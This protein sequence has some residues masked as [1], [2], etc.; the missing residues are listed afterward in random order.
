VIASPTDIVVLEFWCEVPDRPVSD[1]ACLTHVREGLTTD[2]QDTAP[3]FARQRTLP[4]GQRSGR[5]TAATIAKRFSALALNGRAEMSEFT[6][7][8]GG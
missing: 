7:S 8:L 6:E 2:P 5:P 4:W 1:H 3:R